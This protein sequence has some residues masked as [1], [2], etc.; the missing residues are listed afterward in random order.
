MFR[1]LVHFEIMGE[2]F[3]Q[4]GAGMAEFV[5][6]LE[7]IC[8]PGLAS[9][10]AWS[11]PTACVAQS[12][13]KNFGTCWGLLGTYSLHG[14][15]ETRSFSEPTGTC[16]GACWNLFGT[17]G[18]RGASETCSFSEPIGTCFGACSNLLG[19]YSLRGANK[20]YGPWNL[21]E[22]AR[23]LQPAWCKHDL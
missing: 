15:N 22:P 4:C 21:L 3:V 13:F 6:R 10:P 2:R 9:V 23:N 12:R 11:E 5:S 18:L 8:K 17:Y 7:C 16:F 14:T 1:G 20:N 19:A